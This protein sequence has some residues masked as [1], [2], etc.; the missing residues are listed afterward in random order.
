M[1]TC[2]TAT[3]STHDAHEDTSEDC[4]WQ[5]ELRDVKHLPKALRPKASTH[6]KLMK[7]VCSH[8]DS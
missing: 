7:K 3:K 1:F 6:K 5:W 8:Q 2:D 4:L